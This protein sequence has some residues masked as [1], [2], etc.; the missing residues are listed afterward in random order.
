MMTEYKN[1]I[2][3]D[4]NRMYT[5]TGGLKMGDQEFLLS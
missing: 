2:M 5:L 4:N 1:L 3:E